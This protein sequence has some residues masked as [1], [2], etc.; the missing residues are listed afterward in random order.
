MNELV[1]DLGDRSYPIYIGSKLLSQSELIKKHIS[2]NSALIVSNDVVA[3]LY[4]DETR[5]MLSGLGV[6]TFILPGGETCHI[7]DYA[8]T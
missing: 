1:V 5:S 4:L 2:G 7:P 6:E 8:T 3:P